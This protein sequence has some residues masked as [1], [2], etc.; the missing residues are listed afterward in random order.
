MIFRKNVYSVGIPAVAIT[1]IKI[2][3]KN[4]SRVIATDSRMIAGDSR[5]IATDSILYYTYYFNKFYL[6]IFIMSTDHFC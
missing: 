6:F 3:I 2:Y 1:Y 4:D 5:V